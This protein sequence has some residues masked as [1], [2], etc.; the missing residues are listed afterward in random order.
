MINYIRFEFDLNI[1]E[2]KILNNVLV[3][4]IKPLAIVSLLPLEE[5]KMASLSYSILFIISVFISLS[6]L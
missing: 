2:N 1:E 3:G 6:N 4:K 5:S